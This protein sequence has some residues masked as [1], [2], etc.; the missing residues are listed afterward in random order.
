MRKYKIELPN[1]TITLNLFCL[2]IGLD[3]KTI[4]FFFV[5]SISL[6][7]VKQREELSAIFSV[8]MEDI[9]IPKFNDDSRS[10]DVNK[11]R[12]LYF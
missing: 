12:K 11:I 7:S 5:Y 6:H 8:E 1:F 10:G 3:L 2:K 9:K 4:Y